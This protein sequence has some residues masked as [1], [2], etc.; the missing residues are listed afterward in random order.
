[1][2]PACR[3]AA[4]PACFRVLSRK[5]PAFQK[6]SA[7]HP[8]CHRTPPCPC[9][10]EPVARTLLTLAIV[11]GLA[12][13]H[14]EDEIAKPRWSLTAE[15]QMLVV[16]SKLALTVVPELLDDATFTQAWERLQPLLATGE[17]KQV[18]DLIV[19][20]QAGAKLSS[21]T[22]EEFRY[23]T[24]FDPPQ[25]PENVP[26]GKEIE[27]LKNWP[28]VGITPTAFEARYVGPSL[29]VQAN[30][31]EDGEWLTARVDSSHVRLLRMDKFDAGVLPSGGHLAV[32]QPQF[33]TVR[34]AL[35]MHLH[36]GQRSLVGVHSLPE[37]E[38]YELFIL[39]VTTQRT[40]VAK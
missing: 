32:E 17:V 10:T 22:A 6:K 24:Q 28:V 4:P 40:G 29:E 25:L 18:A 33:H 5:E 7:L 15:C 36:A 1:M 8:Y 39:R 13:A 35:E 34:S 2:P 31:S 30:V 16:P 27:I 23:A 21:R 11:L 38:G 26:K 9:Y 37:N 20:G 14:A 3:I 12:A 19:R